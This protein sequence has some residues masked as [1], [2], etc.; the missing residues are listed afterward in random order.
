M[1]ADMLHFLF[2]YCGTGG[3][4]ALVER[5]ADQLAVAFNKVRGLANELTAPSSPFRDNLNRA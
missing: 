2:S 3:G 5:K 1:A 4:A